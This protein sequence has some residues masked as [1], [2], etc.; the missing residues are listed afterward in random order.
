MNGCIVYL[1]IF[2]LV[3]SVLGCLLFPMLVIFDGHIWGSY[4]KVNLPKANH[5]SFFYPL[6]L[7]IFTTSKCKE[8]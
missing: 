1:K 7:Y 6:S 8:S 4:V 3:S 5:V 2:V